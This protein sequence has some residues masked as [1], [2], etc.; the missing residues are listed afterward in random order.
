MKVHVA[1]GRNPMHGTIA[2]I[3]ARGYTTCPPVF[4]SNG[5]GMEYAREQLLQRQNHI[6]SAADL[7]H[8][9]LSTGD[10]HYSRRCTY[11][12]QDRDA[13]EVLEIEWMAKGYAGSGPYDALAMDNYLDLLGIP[14]KRVVLSRKVIEHWDG[15]KTVDMPTPLQPELTLA[16]IA[17][18]RRREREF[19]SRLEMDETGID[20][21]LSRFASLY[22]G[23]PLEKMFKTVG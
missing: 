22:E 9:F 3:K 19:Y 17:R 23:M 5:A 1:A 21:I 20:E 16:N 2:I 15:E 12:L 14:V 13:R 7:Q 4:N 8:G 6:L 18:C 11:L 10:G